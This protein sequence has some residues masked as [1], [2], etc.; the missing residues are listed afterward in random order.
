MTRITGYIGRQTIDF[1]KHIIDLFAFGYRLFRLVFRPP[2]TGQALF[3]RVIGEQIYFTGIQALPL[4]ISIAAIFG[5][6]LIIF[7]TQ[8]SGQYNLGKTAVLLIV[9]EIGPIITAL[10]VILRSATAVTIE[11]GYMN[12][13]N[14]IDAVEMAGVDPMRIIC[15][16]RLI[17]ITS[18]ILC[19]FIVFDLVSILGGYAIVWSSTYIPMGNF[20]R[21]IG[22]S[23]TVTDITVGFV[24]A[25]YFGIIITVTSLY[26]GFKTKKQITDIPVRTSRAAIECFFYCLLINVIISSVFY[27]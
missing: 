17:G 19:L 1:F 14:E 12:V 8:V 4:I 18:A 9:R 26:H 21:Q 5:S 2:K 11:V 20:L 16:P 6:M 3:K 24:K 7:F 13:F 15:L 25:I 23:I 22:N 27:L 10:L